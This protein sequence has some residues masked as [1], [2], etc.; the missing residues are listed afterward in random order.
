ME[1]KI[2]NVPQVALGEAK[3]NHFGAGCVLIT[4]PV[5]VGDCWQGSELV[6]EPDFLLSPQALGRASVWGQ[7]SLMYLLSTFS[8]EWKASTGTD[9][10]SRPP[11]YRL[12]LGNIGDDCLAEEV[13]GGAEPQSQLTSYSLNSVSSLGEIGSMMS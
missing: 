2:E 12:M 13:V 8:C 11:K 5:E 4:N 7:G 10:N 1:N 3:K 9:E 6:L